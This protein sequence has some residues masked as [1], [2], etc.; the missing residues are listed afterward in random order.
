MWVSRGG[1]AQVE[2]GDE[3]GELRLVGEVVRAREDGVRSHIGLPDRALAQ[4]LDEAYLSG[5][6]AL[7]EVVAELA[8]PEPFEVDPRRLDGPVE[9]DEP[10]SVRLGHLGPLPFRERARD[11]RVL[12]VEGQTRREQQA[13]ARG[14]DAR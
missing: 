14:L 11:E 10:S 8:A 12:R 6:R 9:R 2:V 4:A 5:E 1:G 3:R 13:Q 7:L